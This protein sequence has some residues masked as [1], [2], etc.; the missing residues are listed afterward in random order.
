MHKTA[1]GAGTVI[2]CA[3]ARAAFAVYSS[4]V[5]GYR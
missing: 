1:A 4:H 2:G 5:H 3:V